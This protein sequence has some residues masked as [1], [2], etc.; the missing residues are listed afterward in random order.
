MGETFTLRAIGYLR[1]PF[2]EK[3]GI[4]RQAGL[5][6]A[7]QAT[8]ELVPP[9]DDPAAFEELDGFSHIWLTYLFHA[10]LGED[11]P[12]RVRPPR[13]GGN[14]RVGVFASRSPYRPN[15]LGISVVRLEGVDV[16]NGHT[17]L[18]VSGADLLDGTPIVDIKPYIPYSDAVAQASAHFA[19]PPVREAVQVEFSEPARRRCRE[20]Q[21]QGYPGLCELIEQ[22]LRQDPRPAYRRGQVDSHAYGFRLYD[23]DIRFHSEGERLVVDEIVAANDAAPS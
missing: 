6:P 11:W 15:A 13:L 21:E 20:H 14:K 8:V 19:S 18:R 2:K 17:R 3:F 10:H 12:R 1:S 7:V 9:Y 4:P 16:E 23:L 22:V 5:V